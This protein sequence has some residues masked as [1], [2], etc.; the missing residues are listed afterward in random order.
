MTGSRASNCRGDGK[1]Q[2]KCVVRSGYD[3]T[4][5][6]HR[7]WVAAPHRNRTSLHR[8]ISYNW[9]AAVIN[10]HHIQC[11]FVRWRGIIRRPSCNRS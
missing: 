1:Q 3:V 7:K 6:G 11:K 4:A 10:H 5:A 2:R 8:A 9:T